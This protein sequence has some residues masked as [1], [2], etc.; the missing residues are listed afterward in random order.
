MAIG[1][2]A[3][4]NP[5]IARITATGWLSLPSTGGMANTNDLLGTDGISG[6][7][8]GNLGDDS[9]SLLYTATLDVGA[10]EPLGV[11]G[12]VLSGFSH[13]TVNRSVLALLKSIRDGF[14]EVPVAT[15]D[16]EIGSYSTPW[17]STA[18][19]VIGENA[20]IFTWSDTPI[21]MTM[22]T[23]APVAYKDGSTAGSITWSAGPNTAT[24]P[25]KV[26]GKIIPPTAWWRLTHPSELG[27]H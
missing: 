3:A 20:S 7:K 18:R 2:L 19:V 22:D 10:P 24:V 6:L 25:L 5:V 8:T 13:Q 15:R 23:T 9:Y 14:H 1:A 4:A 16:Y 21:T 17:G 26:K 12:V 27:G 11:T